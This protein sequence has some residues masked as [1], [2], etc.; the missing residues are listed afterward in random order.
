MLEPKV[1]LGRIDTALHT[2]A[3]LV[4]CVYSGNLK[5]DPD[6]TRVLGED[7]VS[8]LQRFSDRRGFTGR[9]GTL[10]YIPV[11]DD[12]LTLLVGLGEQGKATTESVRIAAATALRF[13]RKLHVQDFSLVWPST[14][15]RGSS[16][17][18]L[19][20][21]AT[22]GTI[23]GA[24]EFDRYRVSTSHP[25][26]A[27]TVTL[28][29]RGSLIKLEQTRRTHRVIAEEV[30][31]ARDL[32]NENADIINPQKIVEFAKKQ[33]AES[34]FDFFAI[35]GNE[36]KKRGL[37]ILHGV[38]RASA[39]PPALIVLEYRGN[40]QSKQRVALVG[41]GVTFD[42]GGI[43]LKTTGAGA[44]PHMHMDMS[45]AATVLS[46]LQCASKLKLKTNLVVVLAVAE[47]AI[48]AESIKPGS[49]IRAY[50]GKTVEIANTDAEG[51]LILSDALA[52][53]V[54]NYRPSMVIDIGT[55]TGAVIFTFGDQ[56]AGLVTNHDQLSR[57]LLRA[58]QKTGEAIWRLP[59]TDGYRQAVR[60]KKSD[61]VN[62]VVTRP[63]RADGIQAGAFLEH[64]TG[65]TPFAHIDISG[66]ANRKRAL[67]Y[68]A[69][70]GTGFGVRL[71]VNF[72]Q[73]SPRSLGK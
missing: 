34:G 9:A 49:V 47:N 58:S 50:N 32:Q 40:P 53:V 1:Q 36:L 17:S 5:L 15:P 31:N 8:A 28:A 60:G 2:R 4:L 37:N 39:W 71:L 55:L 46:V 61:L 59:L 48:G 67:S 21:A 25:H 26:L 11:H 18:D 73:N 41:K 65:D 62:S 70:G 69:S 56:F 14:R 66:V 42:T 52:Y 22:Q 38:G 54:K 44:L 43:N 10:M 68:A 30:N 64:F 20:A 12:H 35:S 23:L 27:V 19:V 6:I 24:Y 45:G 7:Q 3:G 16:Q 51:R 72:L 33:A 13:M 63:E 29:V 57:Q